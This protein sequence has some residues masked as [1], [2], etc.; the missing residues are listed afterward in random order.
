VNNGWGGGGSGE[1]IDASTWFAG[2]IYP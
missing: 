1:W 2:E